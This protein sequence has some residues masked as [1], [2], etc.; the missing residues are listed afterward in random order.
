MRLEA[1]NYD[2]D[3]FITFRAMS[4]GLLT[5]YPIT[6]EYFLLNKQQFILQQLHKPWHRMEM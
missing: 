3:Y 4:H 1:F 6:T 5:L 2:Y